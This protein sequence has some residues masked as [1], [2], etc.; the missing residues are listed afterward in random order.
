MKRFVL[1][2][3]VTLLVFS[4]TTF[5][6]GANP[7]NTPKEEVIYGM[8]DGS[9]V[10]K[11]ISVV[12][13]FVLETD[14]TIADYGLYASVQNLSSVEE[15]AIS[16]NFIS[17][18]AQSGRSSYQGELT[19]RQLPWEVQI[20]Y[21][22]NGQPIDPEDLDGK[23]GNLRIAISTSKN[24][25]EKGTFF[26][27]FS[28]QMTVPM[29][30]DLCKNIITNGATV[31]DNGSTKQFSYVVMPGKDGSIELTADVTDFEMDGITLAGIRMNFDLPLDVDT[32]SNSIDQLVSSAGKLDSGAVKLIEGATAL[33]TGLQQYQ[34]GFSLLNSQI[35]QLQ[36]GAA[37]LQTGIVDLS[38]GLNTLSDQ[39]AE[40]RAG[41]L[42]I[43]D[44][45]FNS[46][47]TQL[48]AMGITLDPGNY[49]DLLAPMV[50][51]PAIDA[52]IAQLDA[53]TDFVDGV[54]SYTLGTTQLA[55][56]AAGLSAGAGS[57]SDGVD[58][59]AAGLDQLY[60]S[61]E[62]LNAGMKTFL[63]GVATYR[64]GTKAFHA[65][66]TRMDKEMSNQLDSLMSLL[67]NN[68]EV[69]RSFI[70]D[71]NTNVNFVQFVIKADGING[72]TKKA[73]TE[74]KQDEKNLWEKFLDLFR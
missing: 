4:S 8:L 15:I 42:S 62:Q 19:N 55:T 26:D 57:L 6:S 50:G 65:G 54:D 3:L 20:S 61:T 48:S 49:A 56:G 37:S 16:G 29:D 13:S 63:E 73:A 28:L 70:S 2:F 46:A 41:A 36:T 5:I 31:A 59:L 24:V 27:D 43:Q 60:R 40:L 64:A 53:I 51:D 34:E 7:D 18:I 11:S 32:I 17:F 58:T 66:A 23:S 71:E 25:L 35:D 52:L 74:P 10:L 21:F 14:G 69:Y 72:E 47:N 1:M 44:S 12:N 9:G 30:M 39:G 45:A 38:S 68:G 67:S 22:L 33:K